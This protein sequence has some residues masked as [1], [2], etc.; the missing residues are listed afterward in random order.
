MPGNACNIFFNSSSVLFS[1]YWLT[2]QSSKYEVRVEVVVFDFHDIRFIRLMDW[3][4]RLCS[5]VDKVIDLM[6]FDMRHGCLRLM[7]G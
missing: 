1:Y 2:M 7:E 6:N 4:C 5:K 3:V